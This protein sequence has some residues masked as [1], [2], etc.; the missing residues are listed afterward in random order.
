MG[1][2]Q[3]TRALWLAAISVWPLLIG[4][5]LDLADL[6]LGDS[7]QGPAWSIAGAMGVVTASLP[8]T[9]ACLAVHAQRATAFSLTGAITGALIGGAIVLWAVATPID[10][11]AGGFYILGAMLTFFG[12]CF[13]GVFFG[14]IHRPD[15]DP[16]TSQH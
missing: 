1:R 15:R 12:A 5:L 11:L 14:L 13:T 8:T 16:P 10:P 9:L 2:K 7:A 6:A 3:T 4:G